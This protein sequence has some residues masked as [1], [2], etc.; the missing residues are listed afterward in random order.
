[1]KHTDVVI[2]GAGP[3]GLFQAFQLGLQGLQCHLIEA[4]PF[5]G[6]QCAELYPDKPIYDIPGIPV[7]SALQLRDHLQDQLKPF[8]AVFHFNQVVQGIENDGDHLRVAT[9]TGTELSC[10]HLVIATG[11]GAFTPVR[12]RLDG[13]EQ[14]EGRQ[15]F[16]GSADASHVEQQQVVITGDTPAAVATAIEVAPQAKRTTLVHR[17][18]RLQTDPDQDAKLADLQSAGKLQL[19]NGKILQFK[20]AATIETLEVQPKTGEVLSLPTDTLLARL[21]SS[22][23]SNDL[24]NWNL[25]TERNLITVDVADYATSRENIYAIG[26]IN[27]YPGKRKLILCG[28]HEATLAAFAIAKKRQPDTPVHTLYTTTSTVLQQRLGVTT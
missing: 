24:Q 16:Y 20:G 23:K 4:L 28:F 21:G 15:L 19:V 5:S 14:F 10:D 18:R 1:M 6:G 27:L 12:L 25:A 2:V 22:P 3:C 9:S 11:A 13:I 8:A 17:K 7:L 26:D